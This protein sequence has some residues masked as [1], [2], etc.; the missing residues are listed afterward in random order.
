MGEM[1]MFT[2][3]NIVKEGLCEEEPFLLSPTR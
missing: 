3:D 2:L 1:G